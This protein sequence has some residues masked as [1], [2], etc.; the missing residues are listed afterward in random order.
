VLIAAARGSG[1]LHD[2]AMTIIMNPA[3]EFV[4][5]SYVRLETVPKAMFFNRKAEA[6]FYE[7]FFASTA[8]WASIDDSTMEETFEE[9]CRSGLSAIDA[10]HVVLA[11]QTGCEE[12]VTT[13]RPGKP[14][15]RTQRVRTVSID[16]D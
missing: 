16:V 4:S 6:D 5:S 13:E 8:A 7:E 9:A 12:L 2:R 10:L 3:R 15:H 11:A 1:R 14:I